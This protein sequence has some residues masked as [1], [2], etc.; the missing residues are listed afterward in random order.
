MRRA[1]FHPG[2]FYRL[3]N[4][5]S[6]A[7]SPEG[8]RLAMEGLGA[9]GRVGRPRARASSPPSC[10][11]WAD[12]AT[13]ARCFEARRTRR[14]DGAHRHADRNAAR[15]R[16]SSSWAAGSAMRCSSPSVRRCARPGSKVLYFAGY[17]KIADRY[18][19][20][21]IEAAA[22]EV[23]WCCDEAPGFAP[24]RARRQGLRRQHRRGD[25]RA[26]LGEPGR[27]E[28]ARC[29]TPNRVVAIGCD[30]MMAAVAAR[31]ATG[32][33]SRIF[34]SPTWRIGSINSPMQCM[35]KEICAQCLQPQRR[36]RDRQ[37]DATCSPASTRTSRSTP[38][39]S[40]ALRDRL[41]QNSLQ[42]KL[43][44]QWI[45]RALVLE[46]ARPKGP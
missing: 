13:C 35:M 17:K 6:L 39:T 43:T 45:D 29:R 30:G 19:V 41:R 15:A 33:S 23:V 24:P 31:A 27:G 16:P 18:K 46:G 4:F 44:A 7:A 25:G 40:P 26:R 21:D 20:A 37:D 34:R 9:H 14:A 28:S 38:W 42:E 2:Q 5:E 10:S 11:R 12:R 22:D 8:T 1:P 3:Q 36:S 32:S